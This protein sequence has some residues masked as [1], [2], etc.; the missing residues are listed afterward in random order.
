M[1]SNLIAAALASAIILVAACNTEPEPVAPELPAD[2]GRFANDV[3]GANVVLPNSNVVDPVN[4]DLTAL[5]PRF[6]QANLATGRR[7]FSQCRTC[8]ALQSGGVGVGPHLQDILGRPAGN[9]EDFSYS[10]ALISTDIVWSIDNLD[11]LLTSP[12]TLLSGTRMLFGGM[13]DE[14]E[15]RDLI[16]YIVTETSPA[17]ALS[18]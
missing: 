8:H 13:A 17:Q 7:L 16:A 9:V 2:T 5:G 3:A 12:S 1:P 11:A 14:D 18:R 10:P 6:A 15:R 4:A